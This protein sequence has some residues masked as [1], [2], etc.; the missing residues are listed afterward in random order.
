[1]K[2]IAERERML[3]KRICALP[4]DLAEIYLADLEAT[5][6]ERLAFFERIAKSDSPVFHSDFSHKIE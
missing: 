4:I 2:L 1:V 5:A 3:L 6:E